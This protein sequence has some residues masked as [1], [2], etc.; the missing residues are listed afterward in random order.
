MIGLL[1]F[2]KAQK[3]NGKLP[4]VVGSVKKCVIKRHGKLH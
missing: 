2:M 4:S 1:L 3:I